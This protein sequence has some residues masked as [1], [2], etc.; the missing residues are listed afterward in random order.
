MQNI[1]K[2]MLAN[3]IVDSCKKNYKLADD[4][5]CYSQD[6][7]ACKNAEAYANNV[8]Q[9]GCI[10]YLKHKS[11]KETRKIIGILQKEADERFGKE[12]ENAD[13]KLS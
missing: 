9:E 5:K 3:L 1:P 10:L 13:D 8:L 6:C 4:Y 11:K 2:Q 7:M 12:K